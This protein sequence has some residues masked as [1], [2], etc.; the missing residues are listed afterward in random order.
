MTSIGPDHYR[1][2]ERYGVEGFEIVRDR[3]VVSSETPQCYWVV[4]DF[5]AHHVGRDDEESKAVVISNRKRVFKNSRRS[6]CHPDIQAAL[7][8]YLMRKT[9]QI[10][11]AQNALILATA[12]AKKVDD[13]IKSGSIA[14]NVLMF[15]DSGLTPTVT[16]Q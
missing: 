2:T 15:D 12:A 6:Y 10:K 16:W 11:Y 3:F 14:P 5:F 9:N 1:Y 8:S 4:P 7:T 13:M